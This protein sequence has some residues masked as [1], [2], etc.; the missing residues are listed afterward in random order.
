MAKNVTLMGASYPDVPAVNLP[1]TGGG[2]ATFTDVTGT[3]ATAADVAQ[4]KVF[5]AADGTETTGTASGGSATIESLSVTANGTYTAPSGV[6]GYSP[7]VVNVPTGGGASNVVQGTFN[8]N[9]DGSQY[10]SIDIDIPYTGN[11]YPVAIQIFP[12]EGAFSYT[13]PFYSLIDRYAIASYS[14]VK[15]QA[16]VPPTYGA[17]GNENKAYVLTGYKST[18]SSATSAAANAKNNAMIFNDKGAEIA[19]GLTVKFRNSKKMAVMVG[20]YASVA[21]YHF[22]EDIEYTYIIIYSE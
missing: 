10:K 20:Y 21:V 11:G 5:Y 12:S 13:G 4:G 19:V 18:A 9:A 1:Q 16:E 7:V 2:T 8:L 6:D 3:T 17:S 22:A 15:A 14:A